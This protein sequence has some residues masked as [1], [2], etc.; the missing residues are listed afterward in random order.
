MP[1][2]TLSTRYCTRGANRFATRAENHHVEQG[3][4]T[5]VV[6]LARNGFGK[7]AGRRRPRGPTPRRRNLA[8]GWPSRCSGGPDV[9]HGD[10][11]DPIVD[12]NVWT[13]AAGLRP[14]DV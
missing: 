14:R 3:G 13:K 6:A 9:L 11:G 10:H 7:T 12:D 5:R 1:S 4:K 8:G 2:V